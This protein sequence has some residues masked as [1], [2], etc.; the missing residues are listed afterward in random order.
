MY[1]QENENKRTKITWCPP[2]ISIYG[3]HMSRAASYLAL[4][5]RRLAPDTSM[6]LQIHIQNSPQYPMVLAPG[7]MHPSKMV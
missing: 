1:F 6:Y 2:F 5:V 7:V 3:T 4:G